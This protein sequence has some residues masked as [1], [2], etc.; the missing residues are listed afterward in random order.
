ML[1]RSAETA[2]PPDSASAHWMH[3]N[4]IKVGLAFG[5]KSL[6][7][8]QNHR[9]LAVARLSKVS[10]KI[11]IQRDANSVFAARPP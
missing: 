10:M 3:T 8:Q 6:H 4:R 2:A 11:M 5:V 7:T 1:V 9:G